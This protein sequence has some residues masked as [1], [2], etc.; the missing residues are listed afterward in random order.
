MNS[1]ITKMAEQIMNG[2]KE[3][4][5]ADNDSLLIGSKI[6]LSLFEETPI[7]DIGSWINDYRHYEG[8]L[9]MSGGNHKSA[10]FE[11]VLHHGL[12]GHMEHIA[13]RKQTVTKPEQMKFLDSLSK[14]CDKLIA[15]STEYSEACLAAAEKTNCTRRKNELLKMAE[16]CKKVPLNPAES[17]WEAVQSYWFMFMLFPDGLGRLDQY[18]YPFYEADVK[19]GILSHDEALELMEELLLSIFR[20]SGGIG[21]EWSALNHGVLAGYRADGKE[22][23]NECTSL[24]LEAVTDLPTWRPQFSYRVTKH[25]TM[26]QF[27]EV[28]EANFKRPDLVMFLND[29]VIVQNLINVGISYED[30]INY[31]ES[32]CNETIITGCSQMGNIE[33]HINIVHSFERLLKDQDTLATIHSFDEFYEAYERELKTDLEIIVA[34]SYARD[35]ATS[36]YSDPIQSLFTDG[37]IESATSIHKGGAKYNYCTWCL[38]G[39][40]NIA[41]SMSMIRQMVFE[42]NKFS[43]LQ[44]SDMLQADWA[45]YEKERSYILNNGRYF[46][47]DDDYVDMLINKIGESVNTITEKYTPYR[48]GSYL[49][50]TLTGYEISHVVFGKCSM[51]TPDGRHAA[52]PFAAS[53]TAYP[54]ADKNGI[55]SY[56][57]SAAKLDGKVFASSVVV[58]LKLDRSLANTEDKRKRLAAIFM[59][60]LRMGGVQLQMNYLS[61]DELILA[62]QNP[63]KYRSLRVRVTGF[64]G[65]F[66]TFDKTLQDEL[67]L[68]SL[69][70]A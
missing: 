8:I 10:D 49:F 46:G 27:Q 31:S 16:I 22:S 6:N 23:H 66:T 38:T 13:R 1:R 57:K 2:S 30:A 45:G 39:I 53:I 58:N 55:T 4:S 62:Q 3:W 60:Y 70:E 37:C 41:D 54:G 19:K 32:G 24:I 50:G 20:I 21:H 64:S 11:Y 40:V 52:D 68:R 63:E 29:D 59:A 61:A 43:L 7:P 26:E 25:T 33:G 65:F 47:N 56:L 42:E 44:L 36:A 18:L 17:F 69:H 9:F 51:A 48:G 5:L 34:S 14:T 67:I 12:K 35:K 28:L 15:I